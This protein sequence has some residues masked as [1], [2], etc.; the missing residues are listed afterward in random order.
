MNINKRLI[1]KK[2]RHLFKRR[3]MFNF[4]NDVTEAS[5]ERVS[6]HTIRKIA[7]I[8]QHV[9]TTKYSDCHGR[10]VQLSERGR[11]NSGWGYI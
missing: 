4:N 2:P 6:S 7:G 1:K 5:F 8:Q 3:L 11:G 10:R 9:R